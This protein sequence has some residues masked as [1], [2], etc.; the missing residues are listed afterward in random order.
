MLLSRV[1]LLVTPCTIAYQVPPSMGFSRQEYWSGV[2]C[3][4]PGD[5]P[6]PGI[7]PRFPALQADALPS[8]PPGKS[9]R[10]INKAKQEE[11]NVKQ[12]LRRNIGYEEQV[13][14]QNKGEGE[15]IVM[16]RTRLRN[17]P[18]SKWERSIYKNFCGTW[19]IQTG[20]PERGEKTVE[21]KILKIYR[22][23]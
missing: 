14:Q 23:I 1:R 21:E 5:L 8:E 9:K 13:K 19:Q 15:K 16:K 12:E 2:P 17:F 4:S 20:V 7:E 18:R 6:N 11:E 22:H 3:P 10:D